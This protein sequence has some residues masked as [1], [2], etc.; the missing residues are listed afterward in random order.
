VEEVAGRE[1]PFRKGINAGN[2]D[3]TGF[4]SYGAAYVLKLEEIVLHSKDNTEMVGVWCD[5]GVGTID[6]RYTIARLAFP[7][8]LDTLWGPVIIAFLLETG[9]RM[10]LKYN[11]CMNLFSRA[12]YKWYCREDSQGCPNSWPRPI[13][14]MLENLTRTR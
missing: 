14:R 1:E 6:R 7:F 13:F 2:A 9:W 10:Q 12:K 8:A 11:N 4:T 5:A 3:G